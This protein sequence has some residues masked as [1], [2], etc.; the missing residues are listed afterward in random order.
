MYKLEVDPTFLRIIEIFHRIGIWGNDDEFGFRKSFMQNLKIFYYFLFSVYVSMGAYNAYRSGDRNQLIFL[1]VV[2][3]A[4][5]IT[6]VKIYLFR[7]KDEILKFFYDPIVTHCT[8]NY[9]ESLIAK[10][11]I[12]KAAAFIKFYTLML[13]LVVSLMSALPIFS[14]DE[15]ILPLSVH[16]N[17][18]SDYDMLDMVLYWMT[19][20]SFDC[21][22]HT[23][24]ISPGT[25]SQ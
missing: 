4:A 15:R 1:T 7:R 5:S 23:E 10:Q 18:E 25:H 6:W 20:L 12:R 19:S 11:K 21:N 24:C 9:G 17:F 16:L 2:G 8:E 3:I 13:I 22:C 14:S